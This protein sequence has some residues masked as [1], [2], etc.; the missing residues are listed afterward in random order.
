[1][2]R[3]KGTIKYQITKSETSEP[4]SVGNEE[5]RESHRVQLCGYRT[6]VQ[7]SSRGRVQHQWSNGGPRLV[8]EIDFYL[9][10][11]LA[12]SPPLPFRPFKRTENE[13]YGILNRADYGG[14]ARLNPIS[15]SRIFRSHYENARI[16]I[17]M[18]NGGPIVL[19]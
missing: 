13:F 18:F 3:H 10:N 9:V 19:L 7:S 17:E 12:K 4:G 11:T 5:E 2:H 16:K 6:I 14:K 8:G 1:M 15:I